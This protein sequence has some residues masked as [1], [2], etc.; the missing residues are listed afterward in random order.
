M[1]RHEPKSWLQ[2]DHSQAV[3]ILLMIV[4]VVLFVMALWRS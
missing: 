1:D 2:T 4:A 3:A